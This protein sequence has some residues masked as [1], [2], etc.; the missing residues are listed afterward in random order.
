MGRLYDIV[1]CL[2][3]SLL[4]IYARRDDM[5]TCDCNGKRWAYFYGFRVGLTN[6]ACIFRYTSRMASTWRFVGI[7]HSGEL[8]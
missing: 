4:A 1:E 3:V 8:H 7:S 2:E 5:T 6:N